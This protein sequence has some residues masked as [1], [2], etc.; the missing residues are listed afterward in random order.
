[1]FH[2]IRL[3]I[4][5]IFSAAARYLGY[6]GT[7]I[8]ISTSHTRNPLP[9]SKACIRHIGITFF[10]SPLTHPFWTPVNRLGNWF[11]TRQGQ[12]LGIVR[13]SGGIDSC[14]RWHRRC[15]QEQGCQNISAR[16]PPFRR[17]DVQNKCAISYQGFCFSMKEEVRL[18]VEIKAS[19]R[20]QSFTACKQNP[21]CY[22]PLPRF[23]LQSCLRACGPVSHCF[24]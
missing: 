22:P 20:L 8:K 6:R 9:K 23:V 24:A 7:A 1:M 3:A 18:L 15:G 2:S 16:D 4:E 14:H 21:A 19:S 5:R 10:R 13:G 12:R 17:P 11:A